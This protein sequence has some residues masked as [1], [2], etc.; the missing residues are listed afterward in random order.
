MPKM[1]THSGA[2]KR[3]R[4]TK[5]GEFK[6]SAAYRRHHAWASTSKRHSLHLRRKKY[7]SEADRANL[8]QVMPYA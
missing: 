3:F 7:I 5:N 8:E 2:K 6:H 1:K 4:K